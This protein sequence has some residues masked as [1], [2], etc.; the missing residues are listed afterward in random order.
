MAASNLAFRL[1]TAAVGIPVLLGLLYLGPAWGWYLLVAAALSVGAFELFA[2]THPDDRVA[3]GVGVSTC[4]ATSVVVYFFTDDARALMTVALVAPIVGMLIPLWRL[5]DIKTVALRVTTGAFGPLYIGACLTTLA[6]LRK[7]QP[8]FEG[9]G[10][11]VL[12]LGLAWASDTGGYFAGRHFGK[13]KLYERVSPKKTIEGSIGGLLGAVLFA[14][15]GHVWF[16]DVL[17]LPHAIVLAVVG[18][19]LGQA[20]DLGESLLKR[21]TGVKDSGAILP[22]HGGILDRVDALIVTSTVV[23]LYTRWFPA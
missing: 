22:G 7:E 1:A 17:P 18:S 14:V 21:A 11:V 9:P 20:G 5:G 16:L 15:V 23:Y 19:A 13:H 2:M 6:L 12:A 3:Q 8:G 10:Y 4:L